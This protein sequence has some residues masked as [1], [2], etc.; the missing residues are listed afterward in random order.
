MKGRD[1]PGQESVTET[2]MK[3]SEVRKQLTSLVDRV[4]GHAT[5]VLIEKADI[6]VAAL[7]SVDD[8]RRLEQLDRDREAGARELERVST[9]FADASPEQAEAEVVRIGA[10]TQRQET[11]TERDER[12]AVIDKMR[13]AFKDVPPEEI[14]RSV[15]SIIREMR[16]SDEVAIRAEAQAADKRRPA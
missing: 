4:S 1:M 7:V 16:E 9:A 5:R 10:E 15:V 6:P 8:L 13:E 11:A 12:F 2:T 14:E 3:I